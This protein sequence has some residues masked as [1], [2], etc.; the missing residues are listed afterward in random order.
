M[1]F[2]MLRSF[3]SKNK[4]EIE[5]LIIQ[6]NPITKTQHFAQ[7]KPN[8]FISLFTVG[9]NNSDSLKTFSICLDWR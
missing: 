9:K 3:Y 2:I 6:Q 4:F 8:N 5:V 1:K 7:Q